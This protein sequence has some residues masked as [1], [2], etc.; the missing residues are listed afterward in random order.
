MEI[1]IE[2]WAIGAARHAYPMYREF[3]DRTPA[4]RGNHRFDSSTTGDRPI[5]Q[6]PVDRRIGG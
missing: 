4:L 6:P 2:G 3:L 1:N 5:Q